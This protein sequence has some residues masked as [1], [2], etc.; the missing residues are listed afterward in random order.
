MFGRSLIAGEEPKSVTQAFMYVIDTYKHEKDPIK[1]SNEKL[2]RYFFFVIRH[3][4]F[5]S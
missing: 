2:V 3:S 4:F 1:K 5:R